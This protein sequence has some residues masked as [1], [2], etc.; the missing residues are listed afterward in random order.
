VDT[1]RKKAYD[2]LRRRSGSTSLRQLTHIDIPNNNRIWAKLE[3]ENPTESAFDRVYPGLFQIAELEGRIVP[4]RTPVIECSTGN[5]GAS[6]AWTAREL[7]F[8]SR[9]I[10]H[11]DS[12]IARIEQIRQLGSELIFSPPGEYGSGYVQLLNTLLEKDR[13][14]ESDHTRRLYAITK[15]APVARTFHY[16]IAREVVAQLTAASRV[17]T[18]SA[19]VAA[20]GSGD[21]ICGVAHELRTLGSNVRIVG[22]ESAE[23]PTVSALMK[24]EM[25]TSKPLPIEDLMLGVTGTNLPPDRLNIDFTL[26]DEVRGVSI[27]DWKYADRLLKER[28]GIEAGR[29]SA[30]SLAAALSLS[31]T[32]ENSD[33]V[34]I[35]FDPAWKYGSA[36]TPRLSSIYQTSPQPGD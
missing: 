1:Q 13:E 22:M 11:A 31:L 33:I 26:I 7:G 35:F 23:M 24:G 14:R 20:V 8:E 6:F 25:L 5:A 28:E 29:T 4:G 16:P 30:G 36:F 27:S 3:F 9:V 10:I 12:P 21:L 2:D 34:V 19:L 32:M 15:I 18:F 17:R